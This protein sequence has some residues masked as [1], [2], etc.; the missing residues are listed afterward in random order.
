MIRFFL[1]DKEK[2][3]NWKRHILIHVI[4]FILCLTI[5]GVTIYEKFGEGGW[6]T[7]VIT[8]ILIGICYLIKKHYNK[9]RKAA[10]QLEDILQKLRPGKKFNN[11]PLKPEEPTAIILVSGF[12]GFGLHTWLSINRKFPHFYKNFIFVSIAEVDQGAFKGTEE[13]QHLAAALEDG[14][15]KY[16]H[17]IRSYGIAADYRMEAG[18]DVVETAT[19]MCQVLAKEFPKSMVFTGKLIFRQEYFY[20]RML[21]NET[22]YAI[23]RRLQWNGIETVILPIRV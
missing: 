23:Q 22:A 15:K 21:H 12:N 17:L 19:Q 11:E 9:V 14:L 10:L 7:L 6:V 8:S 1:R 20:Q 4:G 18:T 5:L 13:I 16:V 3:G 2:D